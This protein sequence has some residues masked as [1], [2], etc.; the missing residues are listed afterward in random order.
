M[1]D[2]DKNSE[3]RRLSQ[4]V[5]KAKSSKDPYESV[6]LTNE[7]TKLSKEILSSRKSNQ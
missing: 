7:I 3:I 5:K 4:L 6:N 1:M 2:K